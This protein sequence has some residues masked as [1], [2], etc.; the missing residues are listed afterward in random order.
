MMG[1]Q[2]TQTQGCRQLR[3]ERR[4]H[5]VQLFVA[6]AGPG[7]RQPCANFKPLCDAASK[8]EPPPEVYTEDELARLPAAA[9]GEDYGAFL[10]L[11]LT[12][13]REQQLCW[14]TRDDVCLERGRG[15]NVPAP[16]KVPKRLTR[17]QQFPKLL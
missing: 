4:A 17:R 6:R 11:V 15:S 16:R 9:E 14:L 5:L 7:D 8:A 13:L 10:T 3:G 2:A 12:G 1:R